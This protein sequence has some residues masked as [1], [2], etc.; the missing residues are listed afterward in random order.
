MKYNEK[1]S[2]ILMEDENQNYYK[3]NVFL[4]D[5]NSL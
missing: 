2:K 5:F 4:D 3:V 1:N